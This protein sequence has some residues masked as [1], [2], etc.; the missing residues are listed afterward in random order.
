MSFRRVRSILVAILFSSLFASASL[1]GAG[2]EL[3]PASAPPGARAIVTGTGLD[4][5]SIT[6]SFAATAG[7]T[8]PATIVSRT[9]TAIEMSVPP[10]A[11]SGAVTVTSASGALA[12]LPFTLLADP[13]FITVVT[14]AASDK[15]HDVLK[16]PAGV[17]AVASGLLYAADTMHHQIISIAPTGQMLVIAG[18]GKPGATDGVANQAQFKEP[19]AVAVDSI[20][21]GIYIADTG[22]NVIRKLTFDGVVTTFAGSGRGESRD[23]SG[24][25]AGF[26]APSGIAVDTAGN[27]YVADMGNDQVRKITPAGVVTTI[28]GGTHGG[29]ADGS[30][31]QSLFAQPRGVACSSSGAVFIADSG[32]NRIRKIENGTVTTIA[33]TGHGDFSDGSA[34]IAEFKNPSGI[35][36]DDGGN[37]YIADAGNNA[38]RKIAGGIVSTVSGSG[39]GRYTDGAVATAEF[40]SPIGIAIEGAIF[41][42]DSKNDALRVV[43]PAVTFTATT[44]NQGAASGGTLI[45]VLG[46]GFVPGATQV[47]IGGTPVADSAM[48]YVSST[49]LLVTTPPHDVSGLVDVVVTTPAGSST[50]RNAYTYGLAAPS[51]GL[52]SKTKGRTSGGETVTLTGSNFVL[53]QTTVRLGAADATQVIVTST[54]SLSFV[55]PAGSAGP[56]A[57]SVTTAGGTATQ[58]AAFQY[59]A[60][61]VILSFTPTQGTPGTVVTITGQNFDPLPSG[62]A[63]AFAGTP[64]VISSAAATQL[65]VVV[66]NGAGNGVITVTTAGGTG[67][68][69]TVFSTSSMTLAITTPTLAFAQDVSVP[70]N[71]LTRTGD[72][73]G[74]DVTSQAVWSTSASAVATI[75]ANGV[76]TGRGAGT[77]TI[78]ATYNGLTAS[79]TVH[80]NAVVVPILMPA[81]LDATVAQP[82]SDAIR[83]LYTGPSA[84]QTGVAAD[85][86]DALRAATIRGSVHDGA[87]NPAAAVTITVVGHPEFGQ[88]RRAQ[89]ESSTSP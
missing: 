78:T 54:T 69:A 20:R 23:G 13:P 67:T 40:N 60:A 75:S 70:F 42:A 85:A 6:V 15:A 25:L 65:V 64:A 1:F 82:L 79:A 88:R 50:G 26:K 22:N 83:F 24:S 41:V 2:F 34:A 51:I 81:P 68:S 17:A 46:S 18:T 48:T 16:Q 71:A 77:A 43:Y 74:T 86:I 10:A 58:A 73:L 47:T 39:K 36:A 57:I 45:R 28:A 63:V 61:P 9:P 32:N 49:E 59:M 3:L 5:P 27:V 56:V 53:G 62:N 21:S 72:G 31:A 76:A 35:V 12:T 19:G 29:F 89:M 80:V 44:P 4:D 66:P 87:G 84:V 38:I 7:G 14:K 37:L 30:A 55:A 33:G 8:L 11:T 52:L